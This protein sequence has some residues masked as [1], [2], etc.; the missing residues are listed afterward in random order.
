MV[1]SCTYFNF[2]SFCIHHFQEK[3]IFQ[4][5][6][7]NLILKMAQHTAQYTTM[8]WQNWS[9]AGEHIVNK[10]KKT[11]THASGGNA[12]GC[13]RFLPY[14]WAASW[15]NQQND[16]RPAKTPISLSIRCPHEESLGSQLSMHSKDSDQTGRM[17]WLIW[18]FTGHTCHFVG[19]VTTGPYKFCLENGKRSVIPCTS[20]AADCHIVTH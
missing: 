12:F 11:H 16:V 1:L 4:I 15:Q 14:N 18:V 2:S 8:L 7:Y 19:F 13:P 17:P 10:K 5:T 6:T 9:F 20:H 3:I